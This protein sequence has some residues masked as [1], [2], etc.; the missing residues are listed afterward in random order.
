MRS[1]ALWEGIASLIALDEDGDNYLMRLSRGRVD[2]ECERFNNLGAVGPAWTIAFSGWSN[3]PGGQFE[4]W[5]GSL[6]GYAKSKEHL[7]CMDNRQALHLWHQSR[8]IFQPREIFLR[9]AQ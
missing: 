2:L 8:L 4:L 7:P 6:A 9:G 3:R 1:P 5:V